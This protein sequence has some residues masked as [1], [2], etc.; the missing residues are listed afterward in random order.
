M[1]V[2]GWVKER[3]REWRIER[4]RISVT[5]LTMTMVGLEAVVLNRGVL[6][7]WELIF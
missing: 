3:E 5:T 4:V 2:L 1:V 6:I 7:L